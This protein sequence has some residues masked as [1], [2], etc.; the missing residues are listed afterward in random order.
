V[1]CALRIKVATPFSMKEVYLYL[2][3]V[4]CMWID[5]DLQL[6]DLNLL[7]VV[8]TEAVS[9]LL[10]LVCWRFIDCYFNCSA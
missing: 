10:E 9:R 6:F 5:T 2:T 3:E 4:K 1:V 7:I 8:I